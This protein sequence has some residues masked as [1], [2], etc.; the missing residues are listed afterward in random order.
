MAKNEK[1]NGYH[2]H[3]RWFEFAFNNPDL[4]TPSHGCMISWFIEL[5]NRMDWREKF[6]SP[7][8]QTMA[9]TGISSYNTYK[10]IFNNLVEWG[11]VNVISASKNQYT[12]C[13]I[14][15]SNFD[16]ALIDKDQLHCQNLTK[17]EESTTQ[18]TDSIYKQETI[19]P[20]NFKPNIDNNIGREI[21][22]GITDLTKPE[23]PALEKEKNSGQKEK[24]YPSFDTALSKISN[25]AYW[26]NVR[27]HHK[28]S[29]TDRADLFKIFYEQQEDQYRINF[30]AW[31][32][33][34]KHFY[35]WVPVHKQ[36]LTR[37]SNN[38]SLIN[39]SIINTDR[40]TERSKTRDDLHQ[41]IA[42]SSEFLRLSSGNN[43][44][45]QL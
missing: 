11:F 15:L 7:A 27:E 35:N 12:A 23:Q 25:T 36:K 2:L 1:L 17:Q 41:F 31:S 38:K 10:K 4:I 43:D 39:G 30:P 34:V 14:A 9:A 40:R 37:L 18:S 22:K 6:S 44:L 19:K 32:D 8:S 16:K 21:E 13:V 29:D 45:D 28:V 33:M 20:L 26:R 24:E 5:N 42:R 3:K